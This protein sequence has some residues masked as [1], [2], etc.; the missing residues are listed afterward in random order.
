MAGL[1]DADRC[2]E[3]VR[4]GAR[5]EVEDAVAG[6]E[7]GQVVVVADACERI[8]GSLGDEVE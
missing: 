2:A 6:L 7:C 8:D 4:A 3:H 5:A 1:A